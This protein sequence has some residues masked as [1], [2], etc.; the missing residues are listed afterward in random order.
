MDALVVMPVVVLAAQMWWLTLQI[1]GDEPEVR[2]LRES[3][4]A[5]LA[6][7][8]CMRRCIARQEHDERSRW[9]PRQPR[10]PRE[11]E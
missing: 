10:G 2:R 1:L 3:L 7:M 6:A 8:N 9:G 5:Q 4:N 11:D